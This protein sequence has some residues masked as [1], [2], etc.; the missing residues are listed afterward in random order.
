[1]FLSVYVGEQ[2]LQ[3]TLSRSLRESKHRLASIAQH[4]FFL[5]LCPSEKC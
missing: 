5:S 2:S 4:E 3:E 1:M